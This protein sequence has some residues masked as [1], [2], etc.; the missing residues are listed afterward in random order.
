MPPDV[1]EFFHD[2]PRAS[3]AWGN[4]LLGIDSETLNPQLAEF[5]GVKQGVLVRSVSTKS[6][7]EKA[8]IKAGDVI[9]KVNGTAVNAPSE[10]T[11]ALRSASRAKKDATCTVVRN[12]KEMT[13]DVKLN[14]EPGDREVL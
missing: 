5:F 8:G 13:I 9:V 12:R 10:I 6:A 1:T 3:I 7:A 2:M 11:P 4:P 14:A